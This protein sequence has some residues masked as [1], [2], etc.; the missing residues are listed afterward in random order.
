MSFKNSAISSLYNMDK[1]FETAGT[2]SFTVAAR[3]GSTNGLST[4]SIAHNQSSAP[5]YEAEFSI[6]NTNWYPM[7]GQDEKAFGP[8]DW[9]YCTAYTTSTNL[10]FVAENS[11]TTARTVNVRY[12]MFFKG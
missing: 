10:V 8:F 4:H 11:S 2:S 5:F 3:S 7:E 9:V 1:V 12:W 6:D